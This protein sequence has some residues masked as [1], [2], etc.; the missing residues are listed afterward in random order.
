MRWRGEKKGQQSPMVFLFKRGGGRRRNS[1]QLTSNLIDRPVV[2]RDILHGI[3][4]PSGGGGH[5]NTKHLH[6]RHQTP[7]LVCTARWYLFAKTSPRRPVAIMTFKCPSARRGSFHAHPHS[8]YT[9]KR[10]SG[11]LRILRQVPFGLSALSERA[12]T[13]VVLATA[14]LSTDGS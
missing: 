3:L 10:C 12:Q 7:T 5:C 4:R 13:S 9:D 8:R 11:T 1:A 6:I 14:S 2:P